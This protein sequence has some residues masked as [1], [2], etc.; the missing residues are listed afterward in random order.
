MMHPSPQDELVLAVDIGGTKIAAAVIS[1]SGKIL[2]RHIEPTSQIGPQEGIYQIIRILDELIAQTGSIQDQLVGIGIGIPAVLDTGTDF[3]VWGPNLKG[4]RQVDLR[5]SLERHFKVPVSIEY[6]GHTAVLGEWWQGA[7]K[8]LHTFVSVIIGT[9]VGGGMVLDGHLIR[10][11]NRLAGAVGWFV[12]SE[13]DYPQ[14]EIVRSLGSWEANIA[15]PGL[16]HRARKVLEAGV[17]SSTVLK[18]NGQHPTAED[19]FEAARQG[20]VVASKIAAEEAELLGMGLANIVSLVNPQLII[21][22]GSVGS[23]ADFLLEQVKAVI[24]RYSQPISAQTVQ[25]VTSDLGNDAGLFGAAYGL[26]LRLNQPE[27]K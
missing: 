17:E 23:H 14:K 20:D 26:I 19:I 2:Q 4:W 15:G 11:I 16:A 8:N 9:G 6:D 22:G 24:T 10:G 27:F 7:G 18:I 25:V 5:G 3:I 12:L 1:T 21:L 13:P